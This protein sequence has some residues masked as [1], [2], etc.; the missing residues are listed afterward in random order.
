MIFIRSRRFDCIRSYLKNPQK[1]HSD[2]AVF[3]SSESD[4]SSSGR[5]IHDN[6]ASWIYEASVPWMLLPLLCSGISMTFTNAFYIETIFEMASSKIVGITRKV[7]S[8]SLFQNIPSP[9]GSHSILL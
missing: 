2:P 7:N 4:D 3:W 9:F 8:R 5:R 1:C 6:Y